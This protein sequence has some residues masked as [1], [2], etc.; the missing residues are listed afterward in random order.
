MEKGGR[1]RRKR[2]DHLSVLRVSSQLISAGLIVAIMAVRELPPRGE[3]RGKEREAERRVKKEERRG[4][5]N[6]MDMYKYCVPYIR[7]SNFPAMLQAL[8]TLPPI[9][10]SPLSLVSFPDPPAVLKGGLGTRLHR[11]WPCTIELCI[12]NKNG[13]NFHIH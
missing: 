10:P 1:E 9:L 12:Q 7:R 6:Q 5:E 8:P 2:G 3:R 13:N 4:K 11:W